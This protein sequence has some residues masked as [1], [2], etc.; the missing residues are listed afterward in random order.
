MS[1]YN[2]A[3]YNLLQLHTD[4]LLEFYINLIGS[5][6]GRGSVRGHQKYL[7]CLNIIYFLSLP[8]NLRSYRLHTID[9]NCAKYEHL[10]SQNVCDVDF[11]S[12]MNG[13]T[14]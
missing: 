10:S 2:K 1:I 6:W 9:N 7:L 5:G 3:K 11:T 12:N 13:Q 14:L 8:L 4:K